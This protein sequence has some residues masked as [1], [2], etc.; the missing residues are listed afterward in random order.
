MRGKGE[1][2]L[3]EEKKRGEEKRIREEK[4]REEKRST[5]D[6]RRVRKKS[7]SMRKEKIEKVQVINTTKEGARLL[8]PSQQKKFRY[9]RLFIFDI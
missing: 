4:R 5:Q 8:Q 2:E 3:R 1:G 9:G 6:R 7:W